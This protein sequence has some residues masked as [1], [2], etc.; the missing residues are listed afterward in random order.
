MK[1]TKIVQNPDNVFYAC[2]NC[3]FSEINSHKDS[4]HRSC[5]ISDNYIQGGE[6]FDCQSKTKDYI[7]ILED[8]E[9]LIYF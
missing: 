5:S 8:D 3:I 2:E 4:T 6:F 7:F 9:T 1:L